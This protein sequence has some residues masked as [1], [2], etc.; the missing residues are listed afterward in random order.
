MS[1]IIMLGTAAAT[2]GES[3][4]TCFV[5]E[6]NNQ[7]ILVDTGCSNIVLDNLKKVDI[8]L[9]K[10]HNIF[11]SHK[12][13]DHLLG[14]FWV[15]RS[16]SMLVRK[17]EYEGKLNVYCNSEVAEIIPTF[18][19][20]LLR[21][22][23]SE[24]IDNFI[25]IIIVEDNEKKVI[26]GIEFT[27]FDTQSNEVNLYGFE[28]SIKNKK[29][30]FLG[31]EKC[32]PIHYEKLKNADYVMHEVFCLNR[33]KSSSGLGATVHSSVEDVVNNLKGMNIKNLILYHSE[34]NEKINKKIEFEKVGNELFDGKVI[35]PHDFEVINID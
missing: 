30:V 32:N 22:S 29:I 16:I 23:Q 7:Y 4:N 12:H 3:Y 13:M 35:V 14:L 11:I 8:E 2:A 25:N 18:Y 15:L 20:M 31:D 24:I 5:L 9:K 26:N 6:N 33:D 10:I 19:K 34:N 1:R 21:K 27:F 28:T 17:N